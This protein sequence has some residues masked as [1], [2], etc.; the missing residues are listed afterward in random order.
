MTYQTATDEEDGDGNML[1]IR[2][3]VCLAC[4]AKMLEEDVGR[5]VEEDEEALDELG[6]RTPLL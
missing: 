3:R 5:T 6:R 1:Q 2:C 4:A